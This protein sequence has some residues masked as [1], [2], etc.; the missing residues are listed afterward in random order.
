MKS[1]RD[2]TVNVVIISLKKAEPG[3]ICLENQ[4]IRPTCLEVV[5]VVN[6]PL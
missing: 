6:I 5:V 2:N 3:Y 4:D 1:F